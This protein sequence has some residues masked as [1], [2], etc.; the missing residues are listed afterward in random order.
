MRIY[1]IVGT[2]DRF[3]ASTFKNVHEINPNEIPTER[4]YV[5]GIRTSVR[6]HGMATSWLRQSISLSGASMYDPTKTRAME[7]AM[8]GIIE[9]RGDKNMKGRNRNAAVI[10]VL[11][12]RP[13]ASIPTADSMNAVPELLPTNPAKIVANA[14]VSSDFLIFWGEPSASL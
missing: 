2:S 6:K 3:P 8:L 11:P 14:S 10:A 13:P 9:R 12:V 4:L 5:K 1:K 7:L